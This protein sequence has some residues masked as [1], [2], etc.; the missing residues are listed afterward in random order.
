MLAFEGAVWWPEAE[1][2]SRM[3]EGRRKD[4][5]RMKEGCR[6]GEADGRVGAEGW[7]GKVGRNDGLRWGTKR[8][9]PKK[10]TAPCRLRL[11]MPLNPKMTENKEPESCDLSEHLTSGLT[12]TGLLL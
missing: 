12:A 7:R 5:G 11:W 3:K 1:L 4:A 6:K 8:A 2:E 9:A 10:R